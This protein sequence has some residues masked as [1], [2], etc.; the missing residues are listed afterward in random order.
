MD[1]I[2]AERVRELLHFEPETGVLIWRARSAT[3]SRVRIG[4][5]AG[6][7]RKDGYRVIEIDGRGYRAHR[8]AWLLVHGTWPSVEIDHVNGMR[9]DNRIANLRDV[10][11]SVNKQNVRRARA[12]SGH[13]FIG[14]TRTR[15]RWQSVITVDGKRVHLGMFARGE[16]AS[17]AYLA[18]KRRL[19]P[20]CTI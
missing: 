13:G 7:L 18:A 2:T 20:G 15:G 19:H 1:P 5:A 16:D 4:C 9:D 10:S 6:G 11:K 17:A 3:A 8:I 12:D 14:A